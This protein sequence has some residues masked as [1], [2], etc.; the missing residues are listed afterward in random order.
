M[1]LLEAIKSLKDNKDKFE[2]IFEYQFYDLSK[3][4]DLLGEK[5][6]NFKNQK[7][8]I[9]KDKILEKET[10][11]NP[12]RKKRP[13]PQ[14]FEELENIDPFCSPFDETPRD[15]FERLENESAISAL[16]ISQMAPYHSL[17]IFKKHNFEELEEK[18]FINA[19]VL[20]K[21]WFEKI[22]DI[23]KNIK[24][25]I[26][27]WNFG[28]RSGA[29]IYHPHLQVLSYYHLPAK[30]ESFQKKLENY[31]KIFNSNYLDDYLQI[32]LELKT[33]KIL[34]N[35]KVWFNLTPVK[36]REINFLT[37]LEE[38]NNLS[39]LWRL[40]K[41]YN[42]QSFNLFCFWPNLGFLLDRGEITKKNSDFGSLEIF[43]SPV[44]SY[45]PL[46]EAEKLWIDLG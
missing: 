8:L 17:I 16:N 41:N 5:F 37:N 21:N 11:F 29:S 2:R 39:I 34:N 43:S 31:Q 45:D 26:L 24:T 28:Y 23:D 18:D 22:L 35:F 14:K 46:E 6:E 10:I 4:N 3:I 13:Q 36:E 42:A 40:I 15:Y 32:S 20:A 33:G 38:K 12:S 7:I 27:I 9:I 30:L 19:F 44:V 25:Q 1:K